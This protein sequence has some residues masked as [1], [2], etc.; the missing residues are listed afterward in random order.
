M[1]KTSYKYE[2][3]K[4]EKNGVVISFLWKTETWKAT[5]GEYEPITYHVKV[6]LSDFLR[7]HRTGEIYPWHIT[8]FIRYEH[9]FQERGVEK[10]GIERDWELKK[11]LSKPAM[12]FW[13]KHKEEVDYKQY[14]I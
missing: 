5:T 2:S 3:I 1:A 10:Y 11:K 12:R 9:L 7:D 14:A 8:Y 6:L 13:E 4:E